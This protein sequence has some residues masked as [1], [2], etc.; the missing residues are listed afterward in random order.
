MVAAPVGKLQLAGNKALERSVSFARQRHRIESFH[1]ITV[2]DCRRRIMLAGIAIV[3]LVLWVLGFLVFHVTVAFIHIL[4][5]I[6]AVLLVLHFVR[7]SG[8]AS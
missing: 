6:A 5:I 2:A 7:G 4:L 1:I 3:F 8:A